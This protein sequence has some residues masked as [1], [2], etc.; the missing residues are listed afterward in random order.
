MILKLQKL[1]V[2]I[3]VVW[4]LFSLSLV[5]G[6]ATKGKITGVVLDKNTQQGLPG[7]N[8]QVLGTVLGASTD[9]EGNF[10]INKIPFGQYDVRISMIGYGRQTVKDVAVIVHET[11]SFTVELE[12]AAVEIDPVI[13]TVSKWQQEANNTSASVEVLTAKEIMSRNPIKIED[14][15][16]TA[17]GVQILQ[18]NINI[19]GSDG[20]TFGIG[21]RVLVLLDGVPI[22]TSDMG[23]ANLFMISP[24]DIERAEIVRGAGSAIYGSSAMGGV[25]NFI[26]RKPTPKSRT[27]IRAIAGI[28]DDHHESSYN[29]A[30]GSDTILHF[31]R[32]D[33]THSRQIGNLGLRLSGS[34]SYSTGY[35]DHN[36]FQRYNISTRL[37]YRFPNA[38]QWTFLGNYMY[39]DY[40]V[41]L[42]WLSQR[43]ATRVEE[44]DKVQTRTGITL[45]T[46]Y[47]LPISS[48]MG[49]ELRAFLNRFNLGIQLGSVDFSPAL[50]LGGAIQGTFIPN[51]KF[52]LI[53]GA[54]FKFDRTKSVAY[55]KRNA[56]LVAPF[57]QLDWR[58]ASDFGLTFGGRYD[59]YSIDPD[60]NSNNSEGIVFD[61]FSP[62]VG[63][64]FH[65]FE[66]IT[67]RGSVSNGFKFPV[68]FQLFFD[69]QEIADIV[70]V[71]NTKLKSEKSWSYE[72]GYRE[73]I[74]PTWFV[75]F[76]AFY[77]EVRDMIDARS[78]TGSTANFEN[79]GNVT[80][81]GVEFVSNG[82][83]LNNRLG[84]KVNLTYM[85]PKENGNTRLLPHRQKFIAFV[86]GSY[87]PGPFELQLDYKYSSAQERYL[88]P[89]THQFVPQKVL[90]TQIFFYWKKFT[91]LLGV[92]N[93]FNY[94]YTLRDK[95]PEENRNFIAGVTT[96]F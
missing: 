16:E 91:F 9:L 22:M 74:T 11:P 83:W 55:G 87:R 64:N 37:N 59:R 23:A 25:I 75:E 73:K 84:L 20:W 77:T 4:F 52:A 71:A 27:Y 30:A 56:N 60:P 48:K 61:H 18:E 65:P 8:V 69:N 34:Q 80:I 88:I 21:S 32:Q 29:W 10:V 76:N 89:G 96:E 53:Y 67:L 85:N 6:Q 41:F 92:N 24:A 12:E 46:S 2:R 57:L 17:A 42:T 44:K 43:Q 47:N 3:F 35:T 58:P 19:R 26:T 13:V 62:K 15:L 39:E 31:N 79:I 66:N 81:P 54:D 40:D 1:V 36:K 50:G 5:Y 68:I 78:A 28:Y 82:H 86:G 90:D 51:S 45:F 49:I 70:W 93:I 63:F 7:A 14:A 72:L 33:F 38:S 95:F 94:E